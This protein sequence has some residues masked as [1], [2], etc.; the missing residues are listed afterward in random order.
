MDYSLT[1]FLIELKYYILMFEIFI[2]SLRLRWVNIMI[3]I[4]LLIIVFPSLNAD[5]YVDSSSCLYFC[6]CFT[7]LEI[8]CGGFDSDLYPI[9]FS[10]VYNYSVTFG[11]RK[12]LLNTQNGLNCSYVSMEEKRM[13]LTI[14]VKN[15]PPCDSALKFVSKT[16]SEP[17]FDRVDVTSSDDVDIPLSSSTSSSRKMLTFLLKTTPTISS[18]IKSEKNFESKDEECSTLMLT[19]EIKYS[20]FA[21]VFLL[22]VF[23]CTYLF[24]VCHAFQ[25][26][27]TSCYICQHKR[28]N[29]EFYQM[30]R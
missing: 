21:S 15:M 10:R 14:V 29:D 2:I 9:V 28:V 20:I 23:V 3:F 16:T 26:T 30:E 19:W 4:L 18:T 13:N 6:R 12:L 17:F 7:N 1:C 27:C 25:K 5:K 24:H 8:E 11:Y 22:F